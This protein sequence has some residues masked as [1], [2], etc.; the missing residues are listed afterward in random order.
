M[1]R[2]SSPTPVPGGTSP[3][4]SPFG[5][6]R[7]PTPKASRANL[8]DIPLQV[9]SPEPMSYIPT[10]VPVAI[11]HSLPA[12]KKSQ[13]LPLSAKPSNSAIGP[14]KMRNRPKELPI[15]DIRAFV[16]RAVEGRGAEDGVDRW[17]KTNPAPERKVVRIYAD[18]VY[19]LFHFG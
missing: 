9:S 12:A 1:R 10:D 7:I 6:Q 17:W 16:Q 18:G 14:P 4:I 2:P 13:T 8:A 15:E 19:D 5:G 11:S 3:V